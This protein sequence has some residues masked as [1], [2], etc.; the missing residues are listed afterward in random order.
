QQFRL[1]L[2]PGPPWRPATAP[3]AASWGDVLCHFQGSPCHRFGAA[4]WRPDGPPRVGDLDAG[5][6]RRHEGPDAAPEQPC[7]RPRAFSPAPATPRHS[8]RRM[9]SSPPPVPRG[10]R[11]PAS[12]FS[13]GTGCRVLGQQEIDHAQISAMDV[14]AVTDHL[15]RLLPGHSAGAG[16][17]GLCGPAPTA[18]AS[19]SDPYA[20][21]LAEVFLGVPDAPWPHEPT[22]FPR[23]SPLRQP[24]GSAWQQAGA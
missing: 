7:V 23:A 16:M 8:P 14:M 21:V 1:P 5:P 20:N 19:K 6:P 18:G 3:P 24:A 9:P 17:E 22:G 2:P 15:T 10:V 4:A 11:R 12:C 13:P